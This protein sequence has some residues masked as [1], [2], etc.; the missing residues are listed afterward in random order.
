[1]MIQSVFIAQALYGKT[2]RRWLPWW[3]VVNTMKRYFLPR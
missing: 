3:I 1:M 2:Q